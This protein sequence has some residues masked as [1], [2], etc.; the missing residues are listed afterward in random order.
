[1]V[2]AQ[3]EEEDETFEEHDKS[4]R[5]TTLEGEDDYDDIYGHYATPTLPPIPPK[6][7]YYNQQARRHE[8][9]QRNASS[10]QSDMTSSSRW[11][12]W[13]SSKSA[14]NDSQS[15]YKSRHAAGTASISRRTIPL[16]SPAADQ[17]SWLPRTWATR[18]FL[19]VTLSEA[20]AD[21][22]IE[23][24]LFTR[25]QHLAGSITDGQGNF[26][27]LPVFVMVFGMAHVYQC[28]L[29]VDSVI[30]RNSIL[31][32]G[33]VIFNT[34]FLVYALIQITEIRDVLGDGVVSGTSQSVPVQVLTGAIP[35]I[36]GASTLVFA[37]LSWFIYKDFGWQIYK[38]IGADRRLKKA[39][40]HFQIF[41]CLLKFDF[42]VFIAYCLQLVLIVLKKD[43]AERWVTIFAAPVALL[44]LI[45]AWY[46]V[47]REM[48]WGM[49]VFMA[50]LVG[51]AGYF[52]YKTF[53][54]WSERT[55]TYKEV[56]KSLTVFTVLSLGLL[57]ATFIMSV[58]C[59]MNF[60]MGL[61]GA[62][63]RTAEERK[64]A[65]EGLS[66]SNSMD[67]SSPYHQHGTP[68]YFHPRHLRGSSK[69]MLPLQS[70]SSLQL[71]RP[72][73]NPR[74]SLD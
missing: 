49:A 23:S 58:R 65:K 50:G 14:L 41:V 20:A 21:V 32:F 24:V 7:S 33:L 56:Y 48:K 43:A 52:V 30:N 4:K 72:S 47:R 5:D 27:A 64:L 61:K 37:T 13:W 57:V 74:L 29:A 19:L 71:D 51:G 69:G 73:H 70:A 42:F 38:V 36:I 9:L 54:I 67:I 34:A 2:G 40:M 25:Y 26:S 6:S 1:M 60:D 10:E 11:G 35:V 28:L 15:D 22:S 3:S 63:A 66:N 55:T 44:L 31:V 68:T 39:H 18:L 53:K 46:S 8:E 59:L 45:F 12:K 16:S 17:Y 62:M